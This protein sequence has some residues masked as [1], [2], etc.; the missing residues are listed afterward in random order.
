MSNYKVT[1]FDFDGGRGEPIRIAMHAAGLAY[2]DVRWSFPEFAEKRDSLRFNAVPAIEIDGKTITQSNAI[3]RY[4]GK[5]S[6]LYPEDPLQALYCDEVLGALED[7]NHYLVQTFSLKG[8]DL[9]EAREALMAG[10]FKV[11]FTGLEELLVRGGGRYFAGASLSIAD[12]K[13]LQQ[14]KAVRSG[15]LDHIPADYIDK[16]APKLV[17]HQQNTEKE[18][19]VVAYYASLKG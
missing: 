7:L 2:D 16:I 5:M 4:F 19:L 15:T 9:K 3:S 6:G 10:R 18:P 14:V 13:A 1:Y 8:D 11:F 12:L 17:Q